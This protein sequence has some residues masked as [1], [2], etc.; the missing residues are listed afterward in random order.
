MSLLFSIPFYKGTFL[1]TQGS[2]ITK[3]G[4]NAM[5]NLGKGHSLEC[6][7]SNYV[8][9]GTV[10]GDFKTI[11]MEFWLADEVTSASTQNMLGSFHSSLGLVSLGTTSGIFDDETFTL[12]GTSAV[13]T[14]IKDNIP[15]GYNQIQLIWNGSTYDV[16]LNGDMKT[17]YHLSGGANLL[18]NSNLY[19][20]TRESLVHKFT[21]D[22][23]NWEVH[24]NSFTTI[25]VA[26][27][28]QEFE[29]RTL[30]F[31]PKRNFRD[32]SLE[33][34]G[35]ETGLIAGY[36]FGGINAN[37]T[38]DVKGINNLTITGVPQLNN[39]GIKFIQA[40]SEKAAAGNI[41]NTKTIHMRLKLGSTTEVILEGAANDKL[42]LANA[43]TLTYTEFDNAYIDGVD[44]NTLTAGVWNDIIITSSTD[45]DMSAVT[46]ALNNAIYGDL[47]L[48][49]IKFYSDEKDSSWI[50]KKTNEFNSLVFINE[51]FEGNPADGQVKNPIDW[52]PGTGS[53]KVEEISG[54]DTSDIV[55]NGDFDT[56]TD[57]TYDANWT[58][59]GGK[60]H[61]DAVLNAKKLEQSVGF[62][63]NKNYKVTFDISN[64]SGG[65]QLIIADGDI[66][67]LTTYTAYSNGHHVE[68]ITTVGASAILRLYARSGAFS[69]DNISIEEVFL[70]PNGTKYLECTSAGTVILPSDKAYGTWYMSYNK[71]STAVELF[72]RFISNSTTSNA[73][74][75]WLNF[76]TSEAIDVLR[77]GSASLFSS[78]INYVLIDTWYDLKVTRTYAGVWN[79][80]V[81]GAQHGN[82]WVLIPAG[83]G[84]NP[85]TDTTYTTS[86]YC[87]VNFAIGDKITKIIHKRGIE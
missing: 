61:Y 64:Q 86:K 11:I 27:K 22:I 18:S 83:T 36:Q 44:T 12:F 30:I 49:F 1:D 16:W 87:V 62:A 3:V 52:I 68:Y 17:T 56:D 71:L 14:Y 28:F 9:S 60:A 37:L 26:D 24:D 73:G 23:L 13:A 67:L 20:G 47:E 59:S 43:G 84:A 50:T 54:Q 39:E 69:I 5:H 10:A 19:I 63:N 31:P 77:D 80:Y 25:Q 70:N 21:G 34:D 45:V 38:Q 33:V 7:N 41:G 79:T 66:N 51:T 85:A 81:R 58:I 46:L 29:Q 6:L 8:Y 15:A 57:W 32:M 35:D 82:D 78:A 2:T 75:Y 40:N 4:T 76:R 72:V 53:F 65:G 55:T 48:G 42:I 74:S